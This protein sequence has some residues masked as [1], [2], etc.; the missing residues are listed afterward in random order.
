MKR[1]QI[2]FASLVIGLIAILIPVMTACSSTTPTATPTLASIAV[3]PGSAD[4]TVGLNQQFTAN[5][6]YSDGST[7]YITSQVLWT[8]T[9]TTVATIS[10]A[11]LANA[12]STGLAT[13]VAPGTTYIKAA[14][15]DVIS[16]AV[17]LTVVAA[18]TVSSIAVTRISQADLAVGS[19]Q[20]FTATGTYANGSIGDVT[21]QVTWVSS[22]T[23]VATISS[24]GLATGVAPGTTHITAAMSGVTSP[25][26]TLTVA[27]TTTT[28]TGS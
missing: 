7:A 12:S 27:G 23:T 26:L 17:T 4:I 3:M 25:A 6:T 24:A 1:K 18:S 5:G 8:S 15:H 9:D 22:D 11:E 13:G 10:S 16:P 2:R 20:Q 14:L 28:P 19:K 21:P